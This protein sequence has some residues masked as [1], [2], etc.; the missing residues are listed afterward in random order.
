MQ[1]TAT[2]VDSPSAVPLRKRDTPGARHQETL[3]RLAALDVPPSLSVY[4]PPAAVGVVL[5]EHV[6]YLRQLVD[7]C[8]PLFEA[9]ADDAADCGGARIESF[10]I[11][12]GAVEDFVAPITDAA[13]RL[14]KG[15]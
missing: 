13:E 12:R 8:A 14:V 7:L 11:V 10:D 3:R 15:D 4:D 6:T 9:A 1:S 5:L 2:V